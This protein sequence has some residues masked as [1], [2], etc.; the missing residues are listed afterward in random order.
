[1]TTTT[2]LDPHPYRVGWQFVTDHAQHVPGL[3]VS[4]TETEIRVQAN[5]LASFT[6]QLDHL[7]ALATRLGA[8][9]VVQPPLTTEIWAENRTY[10]AWEFRTEYDGVPVLGF[11]HEPVSE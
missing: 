3:F 7:R 8:E 5:P 10:C 2:A 4:V 11:V 1:M 6:E 9:V